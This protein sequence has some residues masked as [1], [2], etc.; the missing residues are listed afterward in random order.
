MYIIWGTELS[1][2][3]SHD[4]TLTAVSFKQS[5]V[6]LLFSLDNVQFSKIAQSC[7]V[8]PPAWL[9]LTCLP[10]RPALTCDIVCECMSHASQGSI[11]LVCVCVCHS[12]DTPHRQR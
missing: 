8:D 10:W 11:R 3:P 9:F 1:Y 12:P 6:S 7:Q 5:S 2:S 4:R